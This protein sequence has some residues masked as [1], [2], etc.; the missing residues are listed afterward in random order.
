MY[1]KV[2]TILGANSLLAIIILIVE[3]VPQMLMLAMVMTHWHGDIDKAALSFFVSFAN[4]PL[5]VWYLIF[6]FDQQTKFMVIAKIINLAMRSCA[7]H[8]DIF[9]KMYIYD[10]KEVDH[11]ADMLITD[12]TNTDKWNE[13]DA[14]KPFFVLFYQLGYILASPILGKFDD[15]DLCHGL[16]RNAVY[17]QD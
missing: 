11:T 6:Y 1:K 14:S 9:V 5:L 7:H 17:L 12:N 4:I 13:Y 10:E 2:L 8:W 16:S 15:Y 3:G